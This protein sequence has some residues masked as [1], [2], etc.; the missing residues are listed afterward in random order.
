MLG[1][2]GFGVVIALAACSKPTPLPPPATPPPPASVD[3]GADCQRALAH[4]VSLA[5]RAIGEGPSNAARTAFLQRCVAAASPQAGVDCVLALRALRRASADAVLE[6]AVR[7][8][9]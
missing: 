8:F 6:P 7:C 5:I 9:R 3:P 4:G 2:L 1:S